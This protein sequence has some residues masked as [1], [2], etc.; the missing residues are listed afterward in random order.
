MFDNFRGGHAIYKLLLKERV[1]FS[2]SCKFPFIL[3]LSEKGVNNVQYGD[4]FFFFFFFFFNVHVFISTAV[5]RGM[6]MTRLSI[7]Y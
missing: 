2:V 7:L 6:L 5:S 1:L 3:E 4:V